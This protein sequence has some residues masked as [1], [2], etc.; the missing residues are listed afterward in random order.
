MTA[1]TEVLTSA[2]AEA[3]WGLATG[4]VRAACGR[5]VIPATGCRKS[6]GTWLVLRQA[7]VA[8]YGDE[9]C[10]GCGKPSHYVSSG[11]HTLCPTCWVEFHNPEH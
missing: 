6:G 9:V 11:D 1:L 10:I 7:M 3:R 8:H 4:T 2:E 5:G